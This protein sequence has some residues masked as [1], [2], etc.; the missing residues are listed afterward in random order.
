VTEALFFEARV[1]RD[2]AGADPGALFAVIGCTLLDDG[3]IEAYARF[4]KSNMD[5]LL[6]LR[7][8]RIEVPA[9]FIRSAAPAPMK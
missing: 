4:A 3:T 1:E 5:E 2:D 9:R 8:Y 7:F 6:V